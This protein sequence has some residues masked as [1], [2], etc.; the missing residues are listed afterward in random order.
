M[1]NGEVVASANGLPYKSIALRPHHAAHVIGL[2]RYQMPYAGA[3]II[4]LNE[5]GGRL[6]AQ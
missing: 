4:R 5:G 3:H 2:A 6:P 1:P